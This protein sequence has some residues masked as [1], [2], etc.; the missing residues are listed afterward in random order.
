MERAPSEGG[1]F[2]FQWIDRRLRDLS[3]VEIATAS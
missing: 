3:L 2:V 1:S